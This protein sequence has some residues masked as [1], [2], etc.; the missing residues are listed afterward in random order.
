[1]WRQFFAGTDTRLSCAMDSCTAFLP[2]CGRN[3]RPRWRIRRDWTVG[4]GRQG[5]RVHRL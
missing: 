4:V 1:M 5:G 3:S 2:G